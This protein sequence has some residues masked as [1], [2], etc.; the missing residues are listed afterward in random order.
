MPSL[1]DARCERRSVV[2][3]G[4]CREV[5]RD[6]AFSSHIVRSSFVP[7]R[8]WRRYASKRVVQISLISLSS[9]EANF[10]SSIITSRKRI[11]HSG[12]STK[13]ENAARGR[14]GWYCGIGALVSVVEVVGAGRIVGVEIF[15]PEEGGEVTLDFGL[16]VIYGRY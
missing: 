8:D 10:S 4:N 13:M 5:R 1:K 2:S 16:S 6:F 12:K 14:G 7:R 11:K 3:I 15:R 9:L